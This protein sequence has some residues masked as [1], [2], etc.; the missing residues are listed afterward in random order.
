MENP[1]QIKVAEDVA[2]LAKR[3]ASAALNVTHELEGTPFLRDNPHIEAWIDRKTGAIALNR[4]AVEASSDPTAK[5]KFLLAHE[6]FHLL[7][8]RKIIS[9][10]AENEELFA[11]KFADNC[12]L[13]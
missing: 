11:D 13:F 2:A 8:I 9:V 3:F 5:K 10:S 7:V 6:F 4:Y 12:L 1:V